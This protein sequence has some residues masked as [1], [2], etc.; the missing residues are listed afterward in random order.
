MRPP[1]K[2]LPRRHLLAGL[3]AA[4]A[5]L[6]VA[7][8]AAWPD[9]PVRLIVPFPPGSGP[10]LLARALAPQ[11]QA[12]FGQPFVV[13]NRPGA[14]GSIGTAA[15]AAATDQHTIGLSIGGPATTARVLDPTLA[16]DPPRDL[17]PISLLARLPY[18][19]LVHAGLAARDAVEMVTAAHATPGGLAYGSIGTGTVSHL[20]MADVQA[21]LGVPMVHVPYRG[22]PQALL[23][24]I[25][26]RIQ[27]GF[28]AGAHALA[29]LREGRVRALAIT[30]ASRQ[31]SLPD[32][33]TMAEAGLP[34]TPSY[35]WIGLFGP[36]SLPRP[37]IRLLAEAATEALGTQA[38]R[39]PL[40]AAG[41]AVVGSGPENF[42]DLLQAETAR[43]APL[44][45]RLGLRA[46]D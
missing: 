31:P 27:A 7:R 2:A 21:R 13:D 11:F 6:R 19:L 26:G 41:F 38:A 29:P 46:A 28:V 3:A 40:E 9:R 25:P 14:G 44:I 43:W 20:L 16:Y 10:D 15:I 35:G 39:T 17:A 12:G 36:A 33:P 37:V 4:P 24:L 34:G 42:A 18:L 32:V 5:L 8:A 22:Y 30:A 45:T 1:C 23:D